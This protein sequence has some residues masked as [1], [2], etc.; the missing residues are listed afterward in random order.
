MTLNVSC[1][2]RQSILKGATTL[3]LE[4]GFN[5]VSMDKIAQAAP[6]SKATLYKYFPSK[7]DLLATVISELCAVLLQT[8]EAV[9]MES[10]SMENNL[11]KIAAGFVDLIFAEEAL[12]I[13][14]LV[15]SECHAFPELALLVYNSGPQA[16][17][18]LLESYLE[19]INQH[20][21]VN[22]PDTAFAADAFFSLLKG[23]LHFQCLLGAKAAPSV[24]QKNEHINKVVGFYMQGFLYAD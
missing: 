14:R 8:I 4:Q 21:R 6:V 23:D 1:S 13:Y 17:L 24:T 15:I 22:I 16:A 18:E 12:A 2:K 7:S 3:F 5:A 10:E 20:K 19:K 11:K 9:S